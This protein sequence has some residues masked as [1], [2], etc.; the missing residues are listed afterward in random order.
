LLASKLDGGTVTLNRELFLG[1]VLQASDALLL[2]VQ[3]SFEIME[4]LLEDLMTRAGGA[5]RAMGADG[6]RL[7]Y[8]ISDGRVDVGSDC[9][10]AM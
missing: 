6:R 9:N 3:V 5:R 4:F 8:I 2:I 10:V 7:Q 1:V